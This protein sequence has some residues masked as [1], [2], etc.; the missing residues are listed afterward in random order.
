MLEQIVRKRFFSDKRCSVIV[1]N[2][3]G[4]LKYQM[5]SFREN[6]IPVSSEKLVNGEDS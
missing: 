6:S 4:E 1:E 2:A 3:E 5:T